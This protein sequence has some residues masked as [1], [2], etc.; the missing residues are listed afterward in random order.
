MPDDDYSAEKPLAFDDSNDDSELRSWPPSYDESNEEPEH[1]SLIRS[2]EEEAELTE[3]VLQLLE[4]QNHDLVSGLEFFLSD[5]DT[6]KENQTESATENSAENNN[7]TNT[8]EIVFEDYPAQLNEQGI[9]DT[10]NDLQ[11]LFGSEFLEE[12][13]RLNSPNNTSKAFDPSFIF[14]ENTETQPH[15]RKVE[16]HFENHNPSPPPPPRTNFSG[17]SYRAFSYSE[18][19]NNEI[20][21]VNEVSAPLVA[22]I[23]ASILF[24]GYTVYQNMNKRYDSLNSSSRRESRRPKSRKDNNFFAFADKKP[25]WSAIKIKSSSLKQEKE[26]I[27][28]A[29][30]SAGRE[31]PFILPDSVLKAIASGKMKGPNSRDQA[32]RFSKKAYRALMVGV[33][34]SAGE[35][36]ALIN[37]KEAVFEVT[38]N[39]TRSKVL[40]AAIKAM[41]KA[42]ENTI[43]V[44]VGDYVANWEIVEIHSPAAGDLGEPFVR[45]Q[46][47]SEFKILNMGK[48]EELGIF[49][50]NNLIDD[51]SSF[52][53]D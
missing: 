1:E 32:E 46:R 39:L 11:T 35:S 53:V 2:P 9:N 18:T 3:R 38:D 44:S 5:L 21:N 52:E 27:K 31:N 43:E 24:I 15:E 30:D 45:L 10:N 6:Y 20:K 47:G 50:Q 34:Q 7:L 41:E 23:I 26:F 29:K 42:L 14:E 40:K 4:E 36:I 51:L 19:D 13:Y 33:V 28:A 48:A 49:D 8:E 25:I 16:D 37:L 12:D 22:L 17:K